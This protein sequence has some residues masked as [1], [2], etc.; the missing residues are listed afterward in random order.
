MFSA[1]LRSDG[2]SAQEPRRDEHLTFVYGRHTP[3]QRIS[4]ILRSRLRG[5]RHRLDGRT[6]SAIRLVPLLFHAGFEFPGLHGDAPGVQRLRR[7]LGWGRWTASLGVPPPRRNMSGRALVTAIAV[8]PTEGGGARLLVLT[9]AYAPDQERILAHRMEVV[10]TLLQSSGLRLSVERVRTTAPVW[11]RVAPSVLAYGALA[12]GTW[13]AVSGSPPPGWTDDVMAEVTLAAPEPASFAALALGYGGA[14]EVSLSSLMQG[15]EAL[16]PEKAR[17]PVSFSFAWAGRVTGRERLVRNLVGLLAGSARPRNPGEIIL[18][19]RELAMLAARGLHRA[20]RPWRD[21]LAMRV[22][23]EIIAGGVPLILKPALA[24]AVKDLQFSDLTGAHAGRVYEVRLP[25]GVTVGR[26]LSEAHAHGR[27][28]TLLGPVLSD[29]Q[30]SRRWRALAEQLVSRPEGEYTLALVEP[31][32]VRGRPH[33]PLNSGPERRIAFPGGILVRHSGGRRPSVRVLSS[34]ALVEILVSHA[35]RGV[36][37]EVHPSEPG[38][39]PV[40]DRVA[41][42]LTAV[43]G[44][45]AVAAE[46]GGAVYL[47][48]GGRERRFRLERFLSRPRMCTVDTEA[49]DLAHGSRIGVRRQRPWMTPLTIE[50]G[51]SLKGQRAQL[52]YMDARGARFLESVPVSWLSDYLDE[53][54]ALL[55]AN[56]RAPGLLAVFA[57]PGIEHALLSAD[58]APPATVVSVHGVLPSRLW[59]ALE[60]DRFGRGQHFGWSTAAEALLSQWPASTPGRVAVKHVAVTDARD[61]AVPQVVQLWVRS[62]ILRRLRTHLQRAWPYR[63]RLE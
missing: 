54:R 28:L 41:R 38:A 57:E 33:D 12:A 21:A 48:S 53:T 15:P 36:H 35:R 22:H 32:E 44:E 13:P 1:T 62:Q 39:R 37:V 30:I 7:R 26:G 40:A 23:R 47:R 25:D 2:Y 43:H 14:G 60:G 51:V 27:A 19:G 45:P 18:V 9:G 10:G 17:D 4:A 61:E 3:G 49:P 20:P 6:Y 24:R 16:A 58:P 52:L 5:L 46:L 34:R 11:A 59:I 63:R 29:R 8:L 31:S 56:P 42:L 50:V 55:A